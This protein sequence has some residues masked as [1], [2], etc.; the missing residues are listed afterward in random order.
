MKDIL[1]VFLRMLDNRELAMY[2]NSTPV[3]YDAYCEY[4]DMAGDSKINSNNN[5]NKKVLG[6]DFETANNQS[7]GNKNDFENHHNKT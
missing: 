6:V 5:V 2:N 7:N 3:A 1:P 4:K